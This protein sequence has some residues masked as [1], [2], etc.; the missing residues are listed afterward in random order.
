[1]TPTLGASTWPL[2]PSLPHTPGDPR[3][4]K[5]YRAQAHIVTGSVASLCACAEFQLQ[6][7]REKM[8][9]RMGSAARRLRRGPHC[10]RADPAPASK[11]QSTARS[12]CPAPPA[13]RSSSQSWPPPPGRGGR[14]R[15]DRRCPGRSSPCSW[16]SA[17][18]R[19]SK[20]P[21]CPASIP[22]VQSL[23][24]HSSAW[25]PSIPFVLPMI[26]LFYCAW[27]SRQELP[28]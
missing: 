7:L 24:L 21:R 12:P 15:S 11:H 17:A 3:L 19:V 1:V 4:A 23:R 22:L 9:P 5:C 26:H 8:M 18:T 10:T 25:Y 13:G 28:P 27:W 20:R 6:L 14:A 16:A 2:L